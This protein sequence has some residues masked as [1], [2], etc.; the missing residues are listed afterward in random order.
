LSLRVSEL[1]LE[2]LE[3]LSKELYDKPSLLTWDML[4]WGVVV[5]VAVT[6]G[7][8][9]ERVGSIEFCK[10]TSEIHLFGVHTLPCQHVSLQY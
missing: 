3:L 6:V 10:L 5:V 4:N 2:Q 9:G 8:T 1:L 7:S